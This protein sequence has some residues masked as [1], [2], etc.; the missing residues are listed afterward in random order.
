MNIYESIAKI[1]SEIDFIGK[2]KQVKEGG[3]YR[4]R[5]V[6]QIGRAHV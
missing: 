5:G 2:D 1:Q 6:D 3:N 4:Y